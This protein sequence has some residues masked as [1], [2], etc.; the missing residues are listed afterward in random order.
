[1]LA[2][3]KQ[4]LRPAAERE[5]SEMTSLYFEIFDP[6]NIRTVLYGLLSLTLFGLSNYKFGLINTQIEN[7][8]FLTCETGMMKNEGN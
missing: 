1:M 7:G 4:W 6:G 5:A 2:M 3:A 8:S